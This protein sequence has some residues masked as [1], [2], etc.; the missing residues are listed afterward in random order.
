MGA[1]RSD[2]I[3]LSKPEIAADTWP[4]RRVVALILLIFGLHVG[5]LWR[6]SGT[7][8][9][10]ER[11]PVR[12][13]PFQF[14]DPV[15]EEAIERVE[16]QDPTLFLLAGRRGFSGSGWLK[17]APFPYQMKIDFEPPLWTEPAVDTLA[18]V[19]RV[20]RDELIPSPPL[21][22]EKPPPT[23]WEVPLN[24]QPIV[25]QPSLVIEGELAG[26]R[27]DT[28]NAL[29][30]ADK[31]LVLA[32]CVVQVTV[33]SDGDVISAVRWSESSSSRMDELAVA[34]ARAARFIPPMEHP[35]ELTFGRL[36][37][38]W[39]AAP[40]AEQKDLDGKGKSNGD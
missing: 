34:F 9:A 39:L 24:R 30:E 11:T 37:F 6:F 13:L 23:V 7:D 14:V 4:R 27:L 19:P 8:L 16:L 12:D 21:F 15:S 18:M 29:P 33:D 26:W 28:T 2:R 38:R 22:A 25:P 40:G 10:L 35:P 32:N 5:L 17:M 3:V 1:D 36:I 31:D 20:G